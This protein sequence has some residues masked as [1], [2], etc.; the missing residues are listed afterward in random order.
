MPP[1]SLSAAAAFSFRV[2]IRS[3]LSCLGFFLVDLPHYSNAAILRHKLTRAL[4]C[5]GEERN[6]A[7]MQTATAAA[8]AT[9]TATAMLSHAR[10]AHSLLTAL[11]VILCDCRACRGSSL[12]AAFVAHSQT[13]TS[14]RRVLLHSSFSFLCARAHRA[15]AALR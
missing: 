1:L 8:T 7:A 9:A 4:D 6:T 3:S 15:R 10:V 14:E 12:V 5:T 11:C 2:L 13:S